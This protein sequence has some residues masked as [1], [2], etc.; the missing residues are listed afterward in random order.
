MVGL[1][2]KVQGARVRGEKETEINQ[3]WGNFSWLFSGEQGSLGTE[4]TE[5]LTKGFYTWKVN[6]GN[7]SS[8]QEK[9]PESHPVFFYSAPNCSCQNMFISN[10]SS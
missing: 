9:P 6:P 7:S 8:E 10:W 1:K 3:G 2:I 4:L 5:S